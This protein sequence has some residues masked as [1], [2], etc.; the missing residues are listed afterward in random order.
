MNDDRKVELLKGEYADACEKYLQAFCKNYQM[1]Y[2]KDAWVADKVGTIACVCDYYFDFSVIKYCVDNE[3]TDFNE[4]MSW[5]DY[6]INCSSLSLDVPNFESWHKGCPRVSDSKLEQLLAMKR[7]L[8]REIK[9]FT[10]K[11]KIVNIF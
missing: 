6:T 7:D 9:E 5:Y 10:G 3:L 1:R 4:L 8:E 11:D 2:E